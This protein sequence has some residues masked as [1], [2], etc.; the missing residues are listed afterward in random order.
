[1]ST[2]VEQVICDL[3]QLSKDELKVVCK[4]LLKQLAVP[5]QEP[6]LVFDDWN[7]LEVDASYAETW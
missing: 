7:D 5:L 1:M 6:E 2:K 4:I 3:Q